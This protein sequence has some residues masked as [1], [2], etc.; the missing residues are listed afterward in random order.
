MALST[1]S[2]N[3]RG[4][5]LAIRG[6]SERLVFTCMSFAT[7]AEPFGLRDIRQAAHFLNVTSHSVC[8]LLAPHFPNSTRL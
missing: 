8:A 3:Q 5:L 6:H 2:V 1:G 7:A 4:D